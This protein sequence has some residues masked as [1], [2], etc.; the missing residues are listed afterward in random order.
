MVISVPL[1]LE[2]DLI[3]LVFTENLLACSFTIHHVID[4]QCSGRGTENFDLRMRPV[5][6][7][8]YDLFFFFDVVA[9]PFYKFIRIE[10]LTFFSYHKAGYV[11]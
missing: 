9:G 4:C 1:A 5:P 3:V 10:K 2:A 8:C 11:C 7:G 6:S